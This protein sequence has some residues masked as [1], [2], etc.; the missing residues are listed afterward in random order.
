[1]ACLNDDGN[2]IFYSKE[3]MSR[4]LSH[5][6]TSGHIPISRNRNNPSFIDICVRWAKLGDES[7]KIHETKHEFQSTR[8]RFKWILAHHIGLKSA[9]LYLEMSRSE[10]VSRNL[11]LARQI[12]EKAIEKGAQPITELEKELKILDAKSFTSTFSSTKSSPSCSL[13]SFHSNENTI[14]GALKQLLDANNDDEDDKSQDHLERVVEKSSLSENLIDKEN[15]PI[16][17]P[18]R[19][20]RNADAVSSHETPPILP[21]ALAA[22]NEKFSI[23]GREYF[24]LEL[25]GKGGS[26]LVFK[27][28]NREFKIYAL[29][30]IRVDDSEMQKAESIRNEISL[31]Q[32]LRGKSHIIHMFDW[33]HDMPK[34][35]IRILF[36]FGE[37]DLSS[38]LKK[39]NGKISNMNTLKSMWQQMLEAVR[40]I[41][42]ERIVHGDLKPSNFLIVRGDLKL[43]DFGISKAISNDTTHI[44]RADQIGT[45]N[46]ISP[47]AIKG[48]D[49]GEEKYKLGRKSDIWSLGCILF[50]MVYGYT[51]FFHIKR[52]ITKLYA[53]TDPK[54]PITYERA[55][56]EVIDVLKLCLQRNPPQR[57]SI[58]QLLSHPFLS[59]ERLVE[60]EQVVGDTQI[61]DLIQRMKD[62]GI[63]QGDLDR[64]TVLEVSMLCIQANN[65]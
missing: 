54:F 21:G 19:N 38:V 16:E 43:I 39:R 12:I 4:V 2:E 31:L 13:D 36:E 50:Q 53:I 27:V 40:V 37:I 32:R 29:K 33:E 28:M 1:M 60:K 18:K 63:V 61:H 17:T 45:L 14:S 52:M 48:I 34:K 57:P 65:L 58:S 10:R 9:Q 44:E 56:P 59:S 7:V 6:V 15:V 25:I 55:D 24:K 8:S 51:P 42:A 35:E 3:L 47:E 26:G 64:N 62:A 11:S 30:K 5:A 22:L 23:N 41:H 49:G 46:Y 20:P